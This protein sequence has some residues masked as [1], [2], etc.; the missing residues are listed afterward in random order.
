MQAEP[1]SDDE[2]FMFTPAH[3]KAYVEPS[4]F[5]I[6]SQD[7]TNPAWVERIESA[8]RIPYA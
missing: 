3:M 7:I 2:D 6:M 4:E 1:D 8:R 5:T